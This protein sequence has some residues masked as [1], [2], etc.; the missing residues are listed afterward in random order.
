MR[1]DGSAPLEPG[2]LHI[3]PRG[4]RML[5]G[6]PNRNGHVTLS[7]LLLVTGGGFV[8]TGAE[9]TAW[10]REAGFVATRVEHLQ[11]PDS[12]VIGRKPA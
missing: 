8:F 4:E 1:P 7:L 5:I 2:A 9:C 12:M 10:M 11:G 6:F 3:W